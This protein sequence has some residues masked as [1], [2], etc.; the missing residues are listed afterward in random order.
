VA[1]LL[2][3]LVRR[4]SARGKGAEEEEGTVGRGGG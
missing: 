3:P 4:Q 2:C 1:F